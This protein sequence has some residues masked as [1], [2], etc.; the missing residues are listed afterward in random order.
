M[1]LRRT[2][3]G[4]EVTGALGEPAH[5]LI[6]DAVEA[7]E[8]AVEW[9]RWIGIAD[10]ARLDDLRALGVRGGGARADVSFDPLP[11]EQKTLVRII[12]HFRADDAALVASFTFAGWTPEAFAW[13]DE[14]GVPLVRFTF[15]GHLDPSNLAAKALLPR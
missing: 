14:Q 7:E 8:L 11:M 12:D 1:P 5:R 6:R 9:L 15:A 4:D 10:A 13:A 2:R 3:S